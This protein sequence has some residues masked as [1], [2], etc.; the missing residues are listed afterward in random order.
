MIFPNSNFTVNDFFQAIYQFT[1]Q[2]HKNGNF[3]KDF[4]VI[5]KLCYELHLSHEILFRWLC[6]FLIPLFFANTKASL[7]LHKIVFKKKL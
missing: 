1:R 5:Q 3:V 7:V 2:N 4:F 6:H